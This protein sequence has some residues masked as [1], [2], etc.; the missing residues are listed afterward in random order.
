MKDTTEWSALREC[1]HTSGLTRT[2]THD[3]S[4][5]LDAPVV[6]KHG[7]LAGIEERA[8]LERLHGR[9]DRVERRAIGGQHSVTRQQRLAQG[10]FVLSLHLGRQ[11]AA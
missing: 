4:V 10:V 11:I 8:V 9:L 6:R 3:G 2:A 7:A 5:H 1:K